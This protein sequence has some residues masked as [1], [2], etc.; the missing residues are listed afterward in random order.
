MLFPKV[1][2]AIGNILFLKKVLNRAICL[3]PTK[4][5]VWP[6]DLALGYMI[7]AEISLLYAAVS[8]KRE[9]LCQKHISYTN[10]PELLKNMAK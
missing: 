7:N 4:I 10:H 2:L 9:N 8:I 3:S 6:I 5:D 1:K